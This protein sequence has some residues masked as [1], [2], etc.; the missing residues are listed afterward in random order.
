MRALG[1][2]RGRGRT[3]NIAASLANRL[4]GTWLATEAIA[5][6]LDYCNM[7]TKLNVTPI[8]LIEVICNDKSAI[9]MASSVPV[10]S[11][12]I[13]EL[14]LHDD[15]SSFFQ[16]LVP[17]VARE[18]TRIAYDEKLITRRQKFVGHPTTKD[19]VPAIGFQLAARRY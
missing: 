17:V 16:K 1:D 9:P 3:D 5:S 12:V 18:L 14:S 11:E 8:P 2:Y 15:N 4:F 7:A 19:G 13:A 10:P 6:Y